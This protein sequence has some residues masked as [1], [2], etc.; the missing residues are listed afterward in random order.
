MK[1]AVAGMLTFI[2]IFIIVFTIL[3]GLGEDKK[4]IITI[5]SIGKEARKIKD[6]FNKGYKSLD[7]EVSGINTKGFKECEIVILNM[8]GSLKSM[9]PEMFDSTKNITLGMV[10]NDS[11]LKLIP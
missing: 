6:E 5:E 1:E 4:G 7:G 2:L 9:T 11:T 8:D 10:I 3:K